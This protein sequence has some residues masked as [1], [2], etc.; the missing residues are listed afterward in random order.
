MSN[1][2]NE[3]LIQLIVNEWNTVYGD[4]SNGDTSREQT[5]Q[6]MTTYLS[7]FPDINYT[8][9]DILAEGN[10]TVIRCTLQATHSGMFM[11]VPATG[12]KIVVKQVEIHKIVGGKIIEAWGFSDSQGIMSQLGITP[13]SVSK[14]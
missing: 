5:I 7:A 6:D 12:K 14:K 2:A 1:T 11:G 13:L 10:K 8:I 9:D 3:E 4:V